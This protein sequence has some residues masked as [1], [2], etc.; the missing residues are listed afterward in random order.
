MCGRSKDEIALEVDHIRAL[1]D[2]GTD[3]LHNLATLCKDCN[4]G[5]SAY[6]FTDYADI[7]VIPPSLEAD[8]KFF[9]D[10]KTGDF[11][12]YHVYLY[13]RD[14]T[15]PATRTESFHHI[16]KI[17]GTQFAT[18]SNPMALADRRRDE[19]TRRF[20][21]DIRTQLVAERKRLVRNEEGICK[22]DG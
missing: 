6:R 1:A 14:H 8:F 7:A 22:V 12:Q 4:L 2:G 10:D 18:S 16:W 13:F 5:K 11:E 9:R 15:H 3:E 17:S 21:T 19:E 20:V